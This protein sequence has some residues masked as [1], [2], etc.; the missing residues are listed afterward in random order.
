M[1]ADDFD[2]KPRPP[3]SAST[4]PSTRADVASAT[5]THNS[6]TTASTS[7]ASSPDLTSFNVAS[8]VSTGP[9]SGCVSG[10]PNA[11]P[12]SATATATRN[13]APSSTFTPNSPT[14]R[15]PSNSSVAVSASLSQQNGDLASAVNYLNPDMASHRPSLPP[16]HTTP[17]TTMSTATMTTSATQ[18]PRPT[19]GFSSI[20]HHASPLTSTSAGYPPLLASQ[21]PIQQP[22]SPYPASTQPPEARKPSPTASNAVTLPSI[23]TM[24][25]I[26]QQPTPPPHPMNN[27]P[28]PPPLSAAPPPPTSSAYSHH[29]MQPAP[30]PAYGLPPSD[31]LARYPLPH[32][33][34]ITT[35]RGPKK[36]RL[37]L[38]SS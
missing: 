27:H 34:R 38:T 21:P 22:Y 23:R 16:P 26:S 24:E 17:A 4:T 1:P 3:D 36:V 14:Q 15:T 9:G 20:S 8:V 32:D 28:A 5:N 30:P 2:N 18:L 35:P 29:A 10:S 6:T 25:A 31:P 13:A 19:P 33:P 12:V 11:A 7:H 37:P